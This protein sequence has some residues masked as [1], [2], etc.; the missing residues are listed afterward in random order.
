[1][2]IDRL[3][4][5][6]LLAATAALST[7]WFA[8][9]AEHSK[10]RAGEPA[11]AKTQAPAQAPKSESPAPQAKSESAAPAAVVAPEAK[12]KNPLHERLAR[13]LA[14]ASPMTDGKDPK[15][16]DLAGEKLGAFADLQKAIGQQILWGGF[17]PKLGY[18]PANHKLTAFDSVVWSKVYLSTF[19]F[20]GEHRVKQEGPRTILEVDAKFRDA[21]DAGDYPYP[22][23]HSAKKWQAYL[24]TQALA[25]VFEGDRLVACY[26]KLYDDPSRPKVTREWDGRWQWTD[27]KGVEQPR[28]ALYSY[29]LSKGNPHVGTL[30]KAYRELEEKFRAQDCLSCHSPD[31]TAK[32]SQLFLL[33]YPNQALSGR[34]ELLTVFSKDT[35]PPTD[36]KKGTKAGLHDDATRG[37]LFRL[38]KAFQAAGDAAL[39]YEYTHAKSAAGSGM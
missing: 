20:T 6:S 1:M 25:L 24:D 9:C 15:A 4:T 34:H 23:W 17:D 32:A 30:D 7:A 19:M 27:E 35:M 18:D 14:E 38:A 33:N 29:L 37:E 2:K 26:R 11:A 39:E 21:L 8:S 28:A 13:G 5:V 22:F 12:A 31:N 36:Q 3:G 10:A 16:R